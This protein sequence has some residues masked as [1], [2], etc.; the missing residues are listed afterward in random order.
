MLLEVLKRLALSQVIGVLF[1]ETKPKL[2]ILPI[3]VT[4]TTH[5]RRLSFLL[6]V[7]NRAVLTAVE[8][9]GPLIVGFRALDQTHI[10]QKRMGYAAILDLTHFSELYRGIAQ[11]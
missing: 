6:G 2:S 7:R 9:I 1:Q 8:T 4:L 11:R 3:N 5:S 10:K